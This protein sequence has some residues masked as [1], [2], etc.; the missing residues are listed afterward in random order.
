LNNRILR[1]LTCTIDRRESNPDSV[2]VLMGTPITGRGV[3]EATIPE[4]NK[5]VLSLIK[6]QNLLGVCVP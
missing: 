2:E 1:T 5:S 4:I 6:N 3:N